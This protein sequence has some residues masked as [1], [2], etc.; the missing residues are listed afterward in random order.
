MAGVGL[1]SGVVGLPAMAAT[2]GAAIEWNPEKPPVV[3]GRP[4]RVQP[5]LA[6]AV[7]KR[8][9]K[10]SWRSWSQIVNEEA[11]AEE[12]TRIAAELKTLPAKAGFPLEI[13]PL[14]KVTTVEQARKQLR[15]LARPGDADI[16]L[17][18]V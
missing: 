4:L 6:H 12:M 8:R 1:A 10:V 17:V 18:Q 5:V 11:A 13:L 14:E 3:T 15:D 16:M 9:E 7:F 2:A